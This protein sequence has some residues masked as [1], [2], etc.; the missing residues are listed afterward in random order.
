M[1]SELNSFLVGISDLS[2]LRSSMEVLIK[3]SWKP[4]R[5]GTALGTDFLS[6]NDLQGQG[7]MSC[8]SRERNTVFFQVRKSLKFSPEGTAAFRHICS[9]TAPAQHSPLTSDAKPSL[10]LPIR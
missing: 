9:L 2:K 10:K 1:K 7:R 6:S 3:F 4:G 8:L 5:V